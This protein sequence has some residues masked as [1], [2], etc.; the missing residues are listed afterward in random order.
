MAHKLAYLQNLGLGGVMYWEI[1]ADRQ[2]SLVD[3]IAAS[4]MAE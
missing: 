1:T 3:L 4:V 2:E